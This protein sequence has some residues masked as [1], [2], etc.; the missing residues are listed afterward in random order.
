ML[1]DKR[2]CPSFPDTGVYNRVHRRVIVRGYG[3]PIT[4]ASFQFALL[5]ALENCIEGYESL[6]ID[7]MFQCD[8]LPVN[9]AAG[10]SDGP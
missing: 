10:V 4:T 2:S 5:A 3:E 1:P 8:I 6:H 7:G 9:L